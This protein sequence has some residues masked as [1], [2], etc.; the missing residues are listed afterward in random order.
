[1]V[2]VMGIESRNRDLIRM[3]VR[4]LMQVI[5]EILRKVKMNEVLYRYNLK[6]LTLITVHRKHIEF[7]NTPGKI[8]DTHY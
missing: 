2:K 4:I 7:P 1:M 8:M 6:Q 5:D 3:I